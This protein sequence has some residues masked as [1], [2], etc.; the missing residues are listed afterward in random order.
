MFRRLEASLETTVELLGEDAVTF[1]LITPILW[2]FHWIRCSQSILF[3]TDLL[4]VYISRQPTWSLGAS[5]QVSPEDISLVELGPTAGPSTSRGAAT[6]SCLRRAAGELQDRDVASGSEDS[7][8][9]KVSASTKATPNLNAPTTVKR[10][11]RR[12]V[13]KGAE[14][15]TRKVERKGAAAATSPHPIGNPSTGIS[16]PASHS[17]FKPILDSKGSKPIRQKRSH[18]KKGIPLQSKKCHQP[19]DGPHSLDPG[20]SLC[21]LP[22][23]TSPQH[24][25]LPPNSIPEPA[26]SPYHPRL[27]E[28]P[29]QQNSGTTLNLSV[30]SLPR[31]PL[32]FSLSSISGHPRLPTLDNQAGQQLSSSSQ[33]PRLSSTSMSPSYF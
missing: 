25:F 8:I 16:L 27:L 7:P 30:S 18:A 19:A 10:K 11:K 4:R 22:I 29:V 3:K 26:S 6:T 5:A 12:K 1:V 31:H 28:C 2:A 24:C 21:P 32:H 14:V 9:A 33:M 13:K 20:R 15:K 17:T 23:P